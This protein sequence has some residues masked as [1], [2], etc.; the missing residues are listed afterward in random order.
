MCAR[1]R[2]TDSQTAMYLPRF[3]VCDAHANAILVRR[4]EEMRHIYGYHEMLVC[5]G[6]LVCAACSPLLFTEIIMIMNGV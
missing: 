3:S 6:M 1:V 4:N 2:P 5:H